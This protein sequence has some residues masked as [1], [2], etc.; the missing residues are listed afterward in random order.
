MSGQTNDQR[1]RRAGEP[2]PDE[3]WIPV[4]EERPPGEPRPTEPSE[5]RAHKRV[6][7]EEQTV[8]VELER[9]AVRV[10]QRDGEDRPAGGEDLFQEGTIR[11]PVRGEEAVVNK[12]AVVTGE[13]AIGRERVAE[14][15]DVSDTIREGRGAGAD[16][17][18]RPRAGFQQAWA[19]F[20]QRFAQ[21]QG[22]PGSTTA[23]DHP[24][25]LEEVEA[26][27]RGG[28]LAARDAGQQVEQNEPERQR[29]HERGA[30]GRSLPSPVEDTQ[31]PDGASGAAGAG[32]PRARARWALLGVGALTPL[33]ALALPGVR[34]SL[35]GTWRVGTRQL[36]SQVADVQTARATRA[37]ERERRQLRQRVA[38]LERA[39]AQRRPGPVQAAASGPPPGARWRTLRPF[40]AGTLLGG[41][42]A[43][44]AAPQTGGA[45]RAQLRQTGGA[46]QE[47]ATERL[48]QAEERA[49]AAQGQARQVLSQV[50]ARVQ[51]GTTPPPGRT[52]APSPPVASAEGSHTND[53]APK[54]GA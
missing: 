26:P 14:R 18:R 30:S 48:A 12:E 42:V 43:L 21:R 28:V 29:A 11:V 39:L 46:L 40:A 36:A 6:V 15:R 17:D 32:R 37:A 44:L 54:H 47:R 27:D 10:E 52:T 35:A 51:G 7:E 2:T 1:H 3:A 13:D 22:G 41:G 25:P 4:A 34:Q 8:P 20:Q 5:G 31:V 53:A 9:E 50:R 24:H 16:R 49:G 23:H 38:R 45:T 19:G 33:A